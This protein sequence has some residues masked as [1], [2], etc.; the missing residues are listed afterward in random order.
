MVYI[1]SAVC[2]KKVCGYSRKYS[3]MS[4]CE[5]IFNEKSFIGTVEGFVLT[6]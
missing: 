3:N 1:L 2:P 5:N 6:F 4:E